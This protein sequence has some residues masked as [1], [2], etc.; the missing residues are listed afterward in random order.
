M[1]SGSAGGWGG[2]WFL[3]SCH[4]YWHFCQLMPT[5][6]AP[7]SDKTSKIVLQS[8]PNFHAHLPSMAYMPK[9]R[10]FNQ[11]NIEI[12]NMARCTTSTDVNMLFLFCMIC[13]WSILSPFMFKGDIIKMTAPYSHWFYCWYFSLQLTALQD[14]FLNWEVGV[15][16]CNCSAISE[17]PLYG[18]FWKLS[19]DIQL[20]P[21]Q[22]C[23]NELSAHYDTGG[24]WTHDPVH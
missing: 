8:L 17:T 5:F 4:L 12:I 10:L 24:T 21:R 19:W 2:G 18:H 3:F 9:M 6:P 1:R 7:C 23:L 11:S 22:Q 16:G 20:L 14:E 13:M 15:L